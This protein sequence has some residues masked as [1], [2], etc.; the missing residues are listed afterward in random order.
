M[1]LKA[2]TRQR[3]VM[4]LHGIKT[5]G[6]WQKDLTPLLSKAGFIIYP[7][8]FGNFWAIEL[9]REK[10][11]DKKLA[12]LLHEYEAIVA[13]EHDPRPSIIAHSFG[14]YLV[15]ALL[16]KYPQ[17]TFDT[18]I[19]CGSIV[20]NDYDWASVLS[21]RR[22]N[23][24]END[25]GSLDAWPTVASRFID[26]AG[27]SGRDG[28]TQEHPALNQRLFKRYGHSDYFS[29]IHFEREWLPTLMLHK[30]EVVDLLLGATGFVANKLKMLRHKVRATVFMRADAT[31][32]HL[33]I[34]P[35]LHVNMNSANGTNPKELTVAIPVD[36]GALSSP[37][38]GEAFDLR[39]PVRSLYREDWRADLARDMV[40][41]ELRWILSVPLLRSANEAF[42]VMNLDG[43]EFDRSV[44]EL[45]ALLTGELI[46]IG[47]AVG[48]LCT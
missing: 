24:V 42:G 17:V 44:G 41:P 10:S 36:Q 45:D 6:T 34:V 7:L 46:A 48:K 14:T 2:A 37:G 23:F 43:L 8:D 35:G 15:A 16:D 4:S 39:K 28:F 30:R 12:W 21:E 1:I 13:K 29:A 20:A 33:K 19:F 3:V 26:G 32:R 5:R 31:A 18:L 25:Y 22:V 9:A 11:R 38:A 27:S 47:Q 40:H